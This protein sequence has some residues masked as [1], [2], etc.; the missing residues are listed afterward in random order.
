MGNL[1]IDTNKRGIREQIRVISWSDVVD[2][3]IGEERFL[4]KSSVRLH[5]DDAV[6]IAK[7]IL[8]E[9]DGEKGKDG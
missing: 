6:K 4:S 1:V 9:Y 5:K 3:D 7:Y 2:V 8:E